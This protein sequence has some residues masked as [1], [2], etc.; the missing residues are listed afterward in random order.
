MKAKRKHAVRRAAHLEGVVVFWV[1]RKARSQRPAVHG[2]ALGM[3]WAVDGLPDYLHNYRWLRMKHHH[4]AAS[5]KN[6]AVF[7]AA[8]DAALRDVLT[9][10][11]LRRV[12]PLTK[13]G[14]YNDAP[15]FAWSDDPAFTSTSTS[16][17]DDE[18]F[19]DALKVLISTM[20]H[21]NGT[22][23]DSWVSWPYDGRRA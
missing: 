17:D 19:I 8:V 5:P 14:F 23:E 9:A 7:D 15:W 1:E 2:W 16:D 4:K 20:D 13:I 12:T 11:E 6:T 22:A 21:G 10:A 3:V 18:A